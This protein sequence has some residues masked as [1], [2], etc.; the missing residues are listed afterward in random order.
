[1]TLIKTHPPAE[2][3][4]PAAK[5]RK[6]KK[7][8]EPESE[9]QY[10]GED[11]LDPGDTLAGF[12]PG[13]IVKEWQ[14][15]R[16]AVDVSRTFTIASSQQHLPAP[17][18]LPARHVPHMA[19]SHLYLVYVTQHKM[20]QE[21]LKGSPSSHSCPQC[22]DG[23]SV[24]AY[25]KRGLKSKPA[26]FSQFRRVFRDRGW[27]T[28]LLFR[29]ESTHAQ[30]TSCFERLRIIGMMS[31][32]PADKVRAARELE[33]HWRDVYLDRQIYSSLS[34]CSRLWDSEVL[35]IVIDS[36]DKSKTAWPR[37]PWGRLP[38]N[39]GHVKR[40]RSIVTGAIAHGS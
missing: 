31:S 32:S 11:W 3:L 15:D 23:H 34:F 17:I 10:D 36:W 6:T 2:V 4:P 33:Q 20:W 12:G 9:I 29:K 21:Q 35:C 24:P 5:R 40:P 38:H 8:E 7:P 28:R 30:C 19:M 37:W 26:S 13:D 18:G 14:P 39:L 16:S 22:P 1:M 25:V 27:C